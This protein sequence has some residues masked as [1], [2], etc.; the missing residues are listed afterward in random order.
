MRRAVYLYLKGLWFYQVDEELLG[1]GRAVYL[2]LKLLWFYQVDEEWPGMRRAVY[3]YLKL[4]W[5][6]Q[7]DEEWLGM[8]RAVYLYP[9]LLWFYQVDEEWLAMRRAVYTARLIPRRR[10]ITQKKT[11]YI[12]NTAK[13]ENQECCTD[14]RS[15]RPPSFCQ[16]QNK[17][18]RPLWQFRHL[19]SR[20]TPA[21]SHSV[22]EHWHVA[23]G[24][25]ALVRVAGY[26]G[27]CHHV[28]QYNNN[29]K[30]NY[31][32]SKAKRS[33]VGWSVVKCSLSNR[34]TNI[35]RRHTDRMKFAAYMAFSFIIFF[36]LLLFL[37]FITV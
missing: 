13:A 20:C 21:M 24:V 17:I 36:H 4:L 34:V 22:G 1:M 15:K 12:S 8:G 11:Y 3:L 10:G 23:G 28:T 19:A 32:C 26:C 33:V 9:K 37:S 25:L 35:I 27:M 2:Y 30:Y 14:C 18:S 29:N 7:V 31:K 5:F 6:Y 16:S